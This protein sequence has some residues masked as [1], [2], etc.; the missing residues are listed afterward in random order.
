MCQPENSKP[1]Y[2]IKDLV[3][4]ELVTQLTKLGV[5]PVEQSKVEGQYEAQSKHLADLQRLVFREKR[6]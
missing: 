1:T 6:S 3:A 5:K 4:R 2:H